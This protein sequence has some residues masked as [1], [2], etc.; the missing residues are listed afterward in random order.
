MLNY[1]SHAILASRRFSLAPVAP[2]C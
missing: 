1:T 2:I